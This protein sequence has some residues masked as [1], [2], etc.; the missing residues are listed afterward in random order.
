V[1]DGDN[2]EESNEDENN[3]FDNSDD[4]DLVEIS[5]KLVDLD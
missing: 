4:V 5:L 2:E 1:I 3:E